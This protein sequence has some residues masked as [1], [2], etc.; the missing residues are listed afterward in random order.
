[1]WANIP[2]SS[3]RGMPRKSKGAESVYPHAPNGS[4]VRMAGPGD[5]KGLSWFNE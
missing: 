2:M 4:P 5:T 1:M 3:A